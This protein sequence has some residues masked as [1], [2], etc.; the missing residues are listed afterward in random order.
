MAKFSSFEFLIICL[1]LLV[2]VN[3]S[4]VIDSIVSSYIYYPDCKT[5]YTNLLTINLSSNSWK[6][7]NMVF[8]RKKSSIL[9]A[10]NLSHY[11]YLSSK[12][13]KT[14]LFDSSNQLL[15][16]YQK[17]IFTQIK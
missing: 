7:A 11:L 13:I 1:V 14:K 5:S 2:D 6:F 17:Y 3:S 15:D 9:L 8:I 4:A 12:K 16:N 10:I